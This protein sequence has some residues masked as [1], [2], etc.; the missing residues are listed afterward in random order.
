MV[1]GFTALTGA[2]SN[3]YLLLITRFLFG[4]GEA[5]A[6]P[7]AAIVVSRWFPASQRASMSGVLLMASQ[8]GGAIAPL[9]IVP[10]QIRYG[11]RASFFIFGIVGVIWA[12][13]WSAWFRDSAAEKAG[14]S[15]AEL[16]EAADFTPAP[17]HGFPWSIALRSESVLAL[18]GVAFCYVY[19]RPVG[20]LQRAVRPDD[21]AAV[22]RRAA[23]VEGRCFESAAQRGPVGSLS[24]GAGAM[25]VSANAS[26]GTHERGTSD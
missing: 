14:V 4:A 21:C 13:V 5:G 16:K 12:A 11:W 25:K 19:V 23:V 8:I 18:A 3:Y 20:E 2:V 7:N 15:A 9:L 17:T 1:V 10:I 24:A 22:R 26:L 6:F